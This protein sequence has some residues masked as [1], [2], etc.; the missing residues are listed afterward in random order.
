MSPALRDRDSPVALLDVVPGDREKQVVVVQ[1]NGSLTIFSEDL[2]STHAEA[3]L[4]F[5]TQRGPDGPGRSNSYSFAFGSTKDDLEAETGC[6]QCGCT[7][8]RLPGR[9]LQSEWARRIGR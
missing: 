8:H 9:G 2:Q 1:Q 3:S 6:G 7:R 4:L 5:P